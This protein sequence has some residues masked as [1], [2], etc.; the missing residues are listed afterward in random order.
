MNRLPDEFLGRMQKLLGDEYP[1]FLDTFELERYYGLRVNTIKISPEEFQAKVPFDL[2]PIPWVEE[3]FY[4]SEEDEPG[5]HQFHSAGL[6][7]IQE[8]SAMAPGALLGVQPGEKILD[9]CAAPG[10]K[11]TQIGARLQGKGVVIANDLNHKRAQ[12]LAMNIERMGLT[13]AFVTQ[14]SPD[15]LAEYFPG[16]FDRILVDAPCSGEGMFRKMPEATDHWSMEYI[17]T[18]ASMQKDILDQAAVMLKP[19]GT[20]IYSTCTFAPEENEGTIQSFLQRHPDFKIKEIPHRSGFQFGHPEWISE[21]SSELKKTIRLWPH[22]LKGEGH[23][24][25]LLEK[26]DGIESSYQP[27]QSTISKKEL[28]DYYEFC[29][30]SLN[31]VPEG[32]FTRFGN[33]L[34][35]TPAELPS[36]AGLKVVRPGWY[37]GELKKKRFEPA[38]GLATGMR[39][40]DVKRRVDLTEKNEIASY[41]R[42]ETLHK[43]GEKG[44]TLVTVDGFPL[45][46]G[47]MVNGILKN[48]Y[49]R[50]MRWFF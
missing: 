19:G 44:W 38:H 21:G 49:P 8:P 50:S 20:L 35:L 12:V 40:E 3:G 31:I 32:Q 10:G 1:A 2:K 9:L 7:Y 43:Q 16:Y 34:Y 45:G 4:Y 26:T 30:D 23:Y 11:A 18:C 6:Y 48:H 27:Y 47:K 13:N 36:F 17:P 5:K 39:A 41:L 24:V 29:Q 28:I 46:W 15:R 42:G 33:H 22:H 25:A 14:E 37:L